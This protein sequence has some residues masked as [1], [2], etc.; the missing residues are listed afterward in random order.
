MRD[1]DN[2][3]IAHELLHTVGA[4]DKYNLSTGLPIFPEGYAEPDKEPLLPQEFAEI[5]G[6]RILVSDNS[7][8]MPESLYQTLIGPVTAH[9]IKW[10]EEDE[11]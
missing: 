1:K 3:I 9:E 8:E 5:M 10:I 4:T 7:S 2:V 11:N 6:G